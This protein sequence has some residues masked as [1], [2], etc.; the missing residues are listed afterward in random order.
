MTDFANLALSSQEGDFLAVVET[1]KGS[2]IK[3]EFDGGCRQ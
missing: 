1:P 2:S 3:W